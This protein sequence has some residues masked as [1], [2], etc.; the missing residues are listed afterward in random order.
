MSAGEKNDADLGKNN[1][2]ESDETLAGD[3]QDNETQLKVI[4]DCLLL[5]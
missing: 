4:R 2:K 3:I 1:I 5:F